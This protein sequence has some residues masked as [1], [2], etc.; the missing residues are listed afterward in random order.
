M[1]WGY[2]SVFQQEIERLNNSS[3]EESSDSSSNN[4]K[5]KIILTILIVLLILFAIFCL[6]LIYVTY[7]NAKDTVRKYKIENLKSENIKTSSELSAVSKNFL[8][9]VTLH[10][11]L[12]KEIHDMIN[13]KNQPK[14]WSKN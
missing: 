1:T 7:R 14:N 8:R 12:E 2:L 4:S 6:A 13:S 11:E 3:L 9:A 5:I 10:P